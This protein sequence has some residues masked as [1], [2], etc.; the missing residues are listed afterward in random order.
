MISCDLKIY[1]FS[2]PFNTR[3]RFSFAQPFVQGKPSLL[4]VND[5]KLVIRTII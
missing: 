4:S 2:P 3:R 5:F 1:F